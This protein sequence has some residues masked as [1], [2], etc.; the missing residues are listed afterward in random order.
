[1]G[2]K[3]SLKKDKNRHKVFLALRKNDKYSVEEWKNAKSE[4]YSVRVPTSLTEFHDSQGRVILLNVA[5]RV[6]L[7][8]PYLRDEY[9]KEVVRFVNKSMDLA[10]AEA[11]K[12]NMNGA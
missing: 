11:L 4:L 5:K 2:K 1:V 8:K 7:Q 10:K 9:K 3:A 12:E 6:M